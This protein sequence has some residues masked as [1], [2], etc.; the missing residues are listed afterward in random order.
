MSARARERF[1]GFKAA[2][3]VDEVR[4]ALR[5]GRVSCERP[6]WLHSG[7]RDTSLYVWTP[8]GS[9]GYA[10]KATLA[11]MIV[12]TTVQGARAA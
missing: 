10:L 5:E 6:E 12:I 8:D 4:L 1:P 9:R 3:I 11:E 2:R 7:H